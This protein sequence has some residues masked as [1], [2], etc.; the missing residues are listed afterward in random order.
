MVSVFDG[1]LEPLKTA[2]EI[3]QDPVGSVKKLGAQAQQTAQD[4]KE[5]L[6]WI[7]SNPI[8][9]KEIAQAA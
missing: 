9:Y 4:A 6:E 2:L 3:V 1:F 7:A 8:K 5:A